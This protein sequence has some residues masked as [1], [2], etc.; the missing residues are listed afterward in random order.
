MKIL[1]NNLRGAVFLVS[2]GDPDQVFTPEDFTEE[3]KMIAL[4]TKQFVEREVLPHLDEFEGQ[5]FEKTVELL[6]KAGGLG[7][8]AHSIPE[9]YGGLGLD[10]VSKG[11][12]GEALGQAGSYGIA[13]SNHT[14]IATLPITYFG[15]DEQ[16]SRFLPKL[17]SGEFF[18]AYC[19]TEPSSG[20]DALSA[21][22]TA[23][24]N[25]EGTHYILNGTKQW[26]TNAGFSDTF[27]VYAKVD[28]DKFT[29]F[30]VE[31]DFQGL[32]LGPEEKKMGIKGSST[33]SVIFE[34]CKVPVENILGEIGKGHVIALNVLNLGRFNLGGICMGA[35]KAV[36]KL[37]IKYTNQRSQFKRPISSFRATQE[38]LA[39]MASRLFAAEAVQYRTAQ[40]LEEALSDLYD[41]SELD[42]IKNQMMEY[43]VECSICKVFGSENLDEIVDE[44]VQL[45]GGYG[46]M[47]EYRI[48][49]FYRDSRINRIF[50]GTNEINRFLIPNLL[51][52]KAKKG[53][54]DLDECIKQ[55][56]REIE[57]T[58]PS[59]EGPLSLE[60]EMV[61][62]IR[63]V[64]LVLT[65]LIFEKY[66]DAF[67]N[68]QES[69]LKLSDVAIYLY[70]SESAVL[71][72]V[73]TI[74]R[75]GMEKEDWKAKLTMN[76]VHDVMLKVETSARQL[77][78]G[79]DLS[80]QSE[81]CRKLV[82]KELG[83]YVVK[84]SFALK[85]DIASKL[86]QTEEYISY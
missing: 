19:L 43:A 37:T 38:K 63:R 13:H 67:A 81:I 9:K 69:L 83:Q 30:I 80:E 65:G 11:I 1:Q 45:H 72:T 50:E 68:E 58:M 57:S 53:E 10:K 16:K 21:Q 47:Q 71:R 7:L 8:L 70:S 4:T 42:S 22:T 49:Q 32:S 18:G 41:A 29:A 55:A 2:Q 54:F 23:I 34:D 85:R 79:L 64:F 66:G 76:Y 35:A 40:L 20:S 5:N 78:N 25:K 62:S 39:N 26:I 6:R 27:I 12:V 60:I 15:N 31:K 36:L 33:R 44:G 61:R 77:L 56:T 75:N 51:F 17:A 84:N 3:H 24:L 82:L 52:K 86:I 14:C 48:E 46:Y 74:Q 73:K 28:G 59:I